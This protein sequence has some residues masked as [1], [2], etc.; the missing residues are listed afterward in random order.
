MYE[1]ECMPIQKAK[2]G[3]KAKYPFAAMSAGDSFKVEDE[4]ALQKA[5]NAANQYGGRN[6]MKFGRRTLS[7]GEKRILRIK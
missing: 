4:A 1:V 7:N 5:L 6:N 2:P 3:P